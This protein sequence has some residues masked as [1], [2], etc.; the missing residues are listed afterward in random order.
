MSGEICFWSACFLVNILCMSR[1][2]NTN[3]P[4]GPKSLCFCT[5][6]ESAASPKTLIWFWELIDSLVMRLCLLKDSLFSFITRNVKNKSFQIQ[7]EFW[8]VS[9]HSVKSS[10]FYFCS[11][12]YKADCV[13]PALQRKQ[14]INENQEWCFIIV[15]QIQFIRHIHF[16]RT[17]VLL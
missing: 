7:I 3:W 15:K 2:R 4:W 1:R 16:Y 12:F 14:T 17:L 9:W 10:N 8:Q 13:R 11:I 5:D 6:G